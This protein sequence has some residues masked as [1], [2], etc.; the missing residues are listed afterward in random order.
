[1]SGLRVYQ[2]AKKFDISSEALVKL[3][4]DIDNEVQSHMSTIDD[5]TVELISRKLAEKKADRA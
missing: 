1:M 4:A 3:L 2:V 5:E